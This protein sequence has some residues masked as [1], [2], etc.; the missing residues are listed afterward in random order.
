[1]SNTLQS[2]DFLRLQ[3]LEQV[4]RARFLARC[5]PIA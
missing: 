5:A 2:A 1:M 4:R 3:Q